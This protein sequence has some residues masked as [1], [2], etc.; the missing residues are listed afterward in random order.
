MVN[1]TKSCFPVTIG[2]YNT[3]IDNLTQDKSNDNEDIMKTAFSKVYH[4]KPGIFTPKDTMGEA[5]SYTRVRVKDFYYSQPD[6]TGASG[7]PYFTFYQYLFYQ[8]AAADPRDFQNA[9]QDIGTQANDWNDGRYY[10][11]DPDM[12]PIEKGTG[13]INANWIP[14]YAKEPAFQYVKQWWSFNPLALSL[15]FVIT[16]L[17]DGWYIY[18][19]PITGYRTDVRTQGNLAAN[20]A[21]PVY[22]PNNVNGLLAPSAYPAI[23]NPNTGNRVVG[24]PF[25]ERLIDLSRYYNKAR[26]LTE[27]NTG[28]AGRV[29]IK[30]LLR[31][32][33]PIW[34]DAK[35][36]DWITAKGN[37]QMAYSFARQ[38]VNADG[39][40]LNDPK[41]G[42]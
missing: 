3:T 31:N 16:P 10:F 9:D 21:Y 39:L 28:G 30:M 34:R 1:F 19:Q 37:K 12:V 7:G 32:N 14:L 6:S 18:T 17:P 5:Q 20:P 22:D 4:L 24:W 41:P 36:S 40:E 33:I 26:V 42:S 35:G 25:G 38:L 15:E 29:I 2:V 23:G 13:N 27:A 11:S 8:Q